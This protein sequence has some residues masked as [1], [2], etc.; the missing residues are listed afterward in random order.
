M[1]DVNFGIK[2]VKLAPA[3]TDGTFPDFS[4][5]GILIPMI[6]IDSFTYD[7]EDDATTDL[8]CEDFDDVF[9]TL[10]GQKGKR[11]LTIQTYDLDAD[12]MAY[13]TGETTV[14]TGSGQSEVTWR[15]EGV[16]FELPSQAM[17]IITRAIDTYPAKQIEYAKLRVEVKESGTLGKN[18]LPNLTL[19]CTKLA[20][21][22]ATGVEI[23]GKRTKVL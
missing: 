6:V 17:Q 4:T 8:E 9:L 7:K 16:G 1:A 11:T 12:V 14:T 18:G 20:N 3:T 10:P 21:M 15:M 13:L 22:N 19:T 2:S 5:G 23:P